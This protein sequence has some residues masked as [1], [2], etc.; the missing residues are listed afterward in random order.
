MMKCALFFLGLAVAVGGCATVKPW[1]RESLAQPGMS[2]DATAGVAA[3]QHM[4]ESR[5]AAV[6][7]LG[8]AGGG[9]GCN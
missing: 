7:G 4:L 8:G 6:G 3:E 5:E 2:F 9:C 1:E